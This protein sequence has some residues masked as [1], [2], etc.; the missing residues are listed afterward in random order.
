MKKIV[1][2]FGG[3]SVESEVSSITGTLISNGLKKHFD[4]VPIFID[5]S[6][7]WLTGKELFNIEIYKNLD[8]KKLTEVTV[9][10]SQNKLYKLKKGKLKELFPISLVV[11]CLHGGVGENGAIKGLFDTLKVPVL[12]SPVLPASLSMDKLATKIFLKGLDIN[13]V[14]YFLG[15]E[16]KKP[17]LKYPII[18]KPNSLGSSI[19]ISVCKT[20]EE[21]K[22]AVLNAKQ[23]DDK[24]ICEKCLENFLEINLGV[25]KLKDKIIVSKP[26][27][28]VPSKDILR[29]EDK[30]IL[31]DRIFPANIDK[32]LRL[33][34]NK[35]ARKIYSSL[36]F[37]GIIRIDFLVKDNEVFVNEINSVPGSLSYYLFFDTLEEFSLLLKELIL[38]CLE[39]F[40]KSQTLIKSFSSSILNLKGTKG[41]KHL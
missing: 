12:S 19:G 15:E 40:N 13:F 32:E 18:V 28:P 33:K 29:F 4:V 9:I 34:I 3:D 27:N 20:N 7:K 14:P 23:F 38:E 16:D 36:N 10:P 2:I 17:K 1:V 26:E 39:K 37:E 41:Q 11:N 5:K 22:K 6:G 24:V 8:Y 25:Y 21:Y 35:I 30:Y 31:G